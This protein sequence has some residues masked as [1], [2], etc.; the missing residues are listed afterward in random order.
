MV[1]LLVSV[2]FAGCGNASCGSGEQADLSGEADTVQTSEVSSLSHTEAAE[3]A[4][5]QAAAET[6]AQSAAGKGAEEPA[7]EPNEETK[8]MPAAA[9]T[10]ETVETAEEQP[11]VYGDDREDI[12]LPLL[13]GKRVAVFSNQTGIV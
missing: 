4:G 5:R 12:Y 10:A 13:E 3:S 7:G 2:L 9:E 1:V 8:D 6:A 11:V